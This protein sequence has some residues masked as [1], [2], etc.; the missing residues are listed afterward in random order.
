M[1][2]ESPPVFFVDILRMGTAERV[3]IHP[4]RGPVLGQPGKQ[5]CFFTVVF[6]PA[7]DPQ[8]PDSRDGQGGVARGGG[9]I[10][11]CLEHHFMV[12]PDTVHES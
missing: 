8:R 1:P 5:A 11:L 4:V 12:G 10:L 7:L 2:P 6:S 9:G 3:F